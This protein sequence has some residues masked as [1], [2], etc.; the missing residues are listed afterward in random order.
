L[1]INFL[2]KSG[3]HEKRL[4]VCFALKA[5]AKVE[6]FLAVSNYFP[7]F[8]MLKNIK[9]IIDAGYQVDRWQKK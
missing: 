2:Q 3:L 7:L 8:F 5:G 1:K 9:K 6:P 4:T